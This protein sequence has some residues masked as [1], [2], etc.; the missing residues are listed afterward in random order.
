MRLDAEQQTTQSGIPGKH[1][2]EEMKTII[3]L[4]MFYFTCYG[5]I[6]GG[7]WDFYFSNEAARVIV[8]KDTT[9]SFGA[10]QGMVVLT[11]LQQYDAYSRECYADSSWVVIFGDEA[12]SYAIWNEKTRCI[13]NNKKGYW[14]IHA[15]MP[16]GEPTFPGFIEYLR[17]MKRFF[18]K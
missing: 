4:I 15:Y 7:D 5:Q 12:S 11:L 3:M 17:Q 10:Y 18:L 16:T 13:Y 1:I 9:E 14:E 8:G 2:G 6:D